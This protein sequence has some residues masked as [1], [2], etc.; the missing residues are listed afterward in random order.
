LDINAA[1]QVAGYYSL[2]GYKGF[3]WSPASATSTTGTAA[4][5]VINP[6][7]ATP[8][9]RIPI[10]ISNTGYSIYASS[11]S[12]ARFP[13]DHRKRSFSPIA[14]TWVNPAYLDVNDYG[15]FV[16]TVIDPF[17]QSAKTFLVI[18]EGMLFLTELS[19]DELWNSTNT[20]I[21]IPNVDFS[22]LDWQSVTFTYPDD[23]FD[24]FG[25]VDP[26]EANGISANHEFS[27]ATDSITQVNYVFRRDAGFNSNFIF[28]KIDDADNTYAMWNG[29]DSQIGRNL[30]SVNDWGE[31]IGLY[32]FTTAT[33]QDYG[34]YEGNFETETNFDYNQGA[35][36]YDGSYKLMPATQTIRG[37]NNQKQVLSA[38]YGVNYLWSDGVSAPLSQFSLGASYA[39]I[40][41]LSDHGQIAFNNRTITILTPDQDSDGDE[42]P[43]DWEMLYGFNPELNDSLDDSDGDGL[44]NFAEYKLGTNPTVAP[45]FDENGEEIDMREGIDSDGDGIPNTWEY[46]NAMDYFDPADAAMDFDRDGFSNLK[47]FQL[48]TDHRGAPSYRIHQPGPFADTLYPTILQAQL[49]AGRNA[50]TCLLPLD[51]SMR[52]D[53]FFCVTPAG[54]SGGQIPA[55]WR[56]DFGSESGSFV[57]YP[58]SAT[59]SPCSAI[60]SS[61]SGAYLGQ[62]YGSHCEFHYW[63]SPTA[64]LISLSGSSEQNDISSLSLAKFSP[65]ALYLTASRITESEG[66][67]AE[68]II[69][70]MPLSE[71]QSWIPVVLPSPAGVSL[72][73]GQMIHVNDYG[74]AVGAGIDQTGKTVAVLWELNA[75]GTAVSTT[76]LQTLA[77][78][79]WATVIGITNQS[80]PIILG[81][82]LSDAGQTRAVAWTSSGA[83]T[84]LG[85]LPDGN[86]SEAIALSPAGFIA[87]K[88]NTVKNGNPVT[89][90]FIANPPQAGTDYR[91][92]PQEYDNESFQIYS[93]ADSGEALGIGHIYTP[94]YRQV[95]T[96]WS[97][98]KSRSLESAIPP[99]SGYVLDAVQ[100]INSNGSL[101]A[102][103]WQDN[104]LVKLLL[105]ADRDTDGDGMPDAYEN[106]NDFN[107]YLAN[108]AEDDADSDG[109][110]D[111]NEFRYATDARNPDS[112]GDGMKDG[113][114]VDWGFLPLDPSDADL[115]PDQDR[116]TNLRESQIGTSPTG[117]YKV[118][119]IL[120]DEAGQYPS[121]HSVNDAGNIIHTGETLYDY[122]TNEDMLPFSSHAQAYHGLIQGAANPVNLPSYAYSTA[123]NEDW[124]LYEGSYQSPSFFLD[125]ESN[126]I[127]GFVTETYYGSDADGSYFSE[128]SYLIPDAVSQVAQE[129]RIPWTTVEQNL[130]FSYDADFYPII[131]YDQALS[132]DAE[133]VSPDGNRRIHRRSDGVAIVLDASG[134][135]VSTLQGPYAWNVINHQGDAAAV[136]YSALSQPDGSQITIPEVI[137]SRNGSS[138]QFPLI[139]AVNANVT[140]KSLSDDGKLLLSIENHAEHGFWH[141][142]AYLLDVNDGSVKRIRMPGLGNESVQSLSRANGMTVGYGPKPFITTTDGTCIRIEAL[143]IK[144]QISDTPISFCEMHP[145]GYSVNHISSS[146]VITVTTTNQV[147]QIE[148]LRL[149]PHNDAD[150]DRVSDD[151]LTSMQKIFN[152]TAIY[153]STIVLIQA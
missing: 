8:L 122:G 32:S 127:R 50:A 14:A 25:D 121:L 133:A 91:L 113:W 150:G 130:Q 119:T 89:V 77:S 47:E 105:T 125:S 146:G 126:A 102:T 111:L 112:D 37:F 137:V 58:D 84:S 104:A 109:L 4:P 92:I 81:N 61:A 114:E 65:A 43:D 93:I 76:Q 100:H 44:N 6:T 11:P 29:F 107:P 117:Y 49:G 62:T 143:R 28:F 21:Q 64:N 98:G 13:A 42:L 41:K 52:D 3:I 10:K 123:N 67:V 54:Y 147:D 73:E 19:F 20:E 17:T 79:G 139:E 9:Q 124:T 134:I 138:S 85:T 80:S 106:L 82:A 38:S 136:S 101:L 15:E 35:F 30:A 5:Y 70:K 68:F 88:A 149:S 26:Y 31:F 74:F 22:S 55:V 90:P 99:S 153:A 36:V 40:C 24:E 51:P 108:N 53:L 34:Y 39:T 87:G 63:A 16:G 46:A 145:A 18:P 110:S 135:Y 75:T 66:S 103:A 78:D 1:G 27:Y 142:I 131:G 12:G 132:P 96:I 95:P 120:T 129:S 118:E 23:Y 60:A 152:Q 71:T 2:S 141:S 59:L 151:F 128:S 148:F 144:N 116:V 86:Y 7:S 69:W 115:D 33:A 56:K 57:T 140:L 45:V 72:V 97:H 48:G 94:A 83:I